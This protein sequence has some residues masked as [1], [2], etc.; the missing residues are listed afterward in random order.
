MLQDSQMALSSDPR[1]AFSDAR[2][3]PHLAVL[4]GLH[5]L[6]HALRFGAE[7]QR[8][9][10]TD[11]L[12]V[13]DLIDGYAPDLPKLLGREPEVVSPEVFQALSPNAPATGV[14]TI[15]K[16]PNVD[17]RALLSNQRPAPVVLLEQPRDLG[18]VGA[19][20]RVAA[21]ADVAGVLTTGTHDPW[22]PAALRG[23]AGLHFA[24]PVTRIAQDELTCDRPLIALDGSGDPLALSELSPRAILAFGSERRG[25]S[26]E[27][28]AR[29]DARV[30]LPMRQG[31]SSLNLATTVAALLYS[32]R[33]CSDQS[34][35]PVDR[36]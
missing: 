29:A 33:L 14:I 31:V 1:K 4:E 2:R 13:G 8:V 3:D 21:A 26:E 10:I 25:L 9:V 35:L 17:L 28:L 6:K 22:N 15:A 18:N 32:W 30:S 27:L 20:V 36:A 5:A 23:S 34:A 19:C 11:P 7:V 24:L 16:R 12:G